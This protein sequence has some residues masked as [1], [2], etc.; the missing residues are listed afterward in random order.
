LQY[1]YITNEVNIQ[2]IYMIPR[3]RYILPSL[4]AISCWFFEFS[5]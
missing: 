1:K 2:A 3:Y 4:A 5:I